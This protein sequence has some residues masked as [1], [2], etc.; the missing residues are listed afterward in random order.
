[1]RIGVIGSGDVGRALTIGFLGRGDE[2][3]IGTRT[4]AHL[5]EWRDQ[6]AKGVH[7]GTFAETAE[8][9]ELIALATL[10]SGT[11]PAL[12]LAGV[13]RFA[14]KVVMDVTNPLVFVEDGPPQ[15]ALGHTDSGGEQVQRWLPDA[16]VVK[17]F[18]SVGNGLF[19]KPD[20]RSGPP[21][22][23]YCG[24]DESAKTAVKKIIEDFGW[25]PFDSGSIEGARLLEPLCI[26]WVVYAFTRQSRNHAFKLVHS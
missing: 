8:F 4:P 13:Q 21:T 12:D 2:V 7:I 22:M 24:N 25:E 26:L 20:L 11:K 3:M 1:M 18:N 5:K 16:K 10:W 15:L 19:V 23:F 6:E 17:A 14:N 9:G